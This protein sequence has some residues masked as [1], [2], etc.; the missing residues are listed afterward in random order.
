[1]DPFVEKIVE[2]LE[3]EINLLY[4]KKEELEASDVPED[5][6]QQ[7]SAG[8]NAG[9]AQA[10]SHAAEMFSRVQQEVDLMTK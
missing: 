6:Y 3:D 8:F 5:K 7:F 4:R 9:Y 10:C 2:M 1:M